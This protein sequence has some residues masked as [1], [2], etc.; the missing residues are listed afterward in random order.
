MRIPAIIGIRRQWQ[1]L[2]LLLVTCM[3]GI[4]SAASVEVTVE[5][6]KGEMRENILLFLSIEQQK[7]HP[8]LSEGRIRRLHK[9]AG[10]EIETALQPFGYYRPVVTSRLTRK[11]E[12]VWTASYQIDPGP[13]LLIRR[14]DITLSG[15]A[16]D[17]PQ[18]QTLLTSSPLRVG[19]ILDQRLYEDLKDSLI[20]LASEHGYFDARLTE[21][22]INIDLTDYAGDVVLH[23]D[24][25]PRYRFGAVLYRQDVLDPGL[26]S[27]YTPFQQGDPYSIVTLIDL[28]QALNDSDYFN[29]VEV[30]P[31]FHVQESLEVPVEVGLTPRPP[32]KYTLGVGYGTDTGARGKVGWEMPRVNR[33]GHRLGTEYKISEIG[34]NLSGRYRIPAKNP[35][36]D[37]YILSAGLSSEH[38]DT[39]ES[40]TRSLGAS[41]VHGRGLWREVISLSFQEERFSIGQD[42]GRS[43]LLMPGINWSRVWANDRINVHKGARLIFDLKAASQ[44]IVSDSSFAQGR[45]QAK[46]ILP[47]LSQGRLIARGSIGGTVTDEFGELPASVRF[48][49]GGSQSVRGYAYNSLGP[50][51]AS[52]DVVGGK[53]LMIGSLEY[54]HRLGQSWSAAV[55]YDIGNAVDTFTEALMEGAGAGL[56][57][58]SPIGP[59]RIDI[60][61]ALSEEKRPWRVHIDIG[62]DL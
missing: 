20:K 55:F 6:V 22:A 12:N 41:L 40:R 7:Q 18:F 28:Q 15:D 35:R 27:R 4:A 46:V 17:D 37:E 32:H 21:H 59:V 36:T 14:L 49:A 25:G 48:F 9:K 57:W 39:S 61:S 42:E 52:G 62:P 38:T 13:P 51:D 43:S 16:T 31:Q 10:K 60:A 3:S 34:D 56:R 23:F 45:L 19:D 58:R 53:H 24:S 26:L 54:E 33:H 8:I 29:S 1:A 30:Q 44:E 50:T 5:G 2:L 47:A 11:D